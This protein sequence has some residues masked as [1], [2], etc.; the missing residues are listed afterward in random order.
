MKKIITIAAA[1]MLVIIDQV[2]KLLTVNYLKPVGTVT[3][4]NGIFN[5]TYVEN[6]GMAFGLLSNQRWIFISLTALVMIVLI[7]AM[8]KL[9]NQGRLFYISVALLVGGGIG[10]L[11]DRI[12]YG[13]VIDYISLSFFPPVCNFADYCVTAGVIIFL[14]HLFFYTDFLKNDEK[15][16]KK[17]GGV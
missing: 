17:D 5:L 12:A 3:V 16:V 8:F 9:K 10:N 15:R 2:L 7:A 14:I 4:I 13:Y 6:T 1:V 11:I